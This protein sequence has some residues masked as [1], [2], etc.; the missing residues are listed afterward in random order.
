MPNCDEQLA[1]NGHNR[2][3]PAN[4]STQPLKLSLPVGVMLDGNPGRLDHDPTQITP[5]FLGDAPS[6]IGFPRLV[7][8]CP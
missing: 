8:A 5:P 3:L 2:F 6:S 1:R 4:A 7:D